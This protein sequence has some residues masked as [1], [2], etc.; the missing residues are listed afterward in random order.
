MQ[1]RDRTNRSD[2]ERE[3]KENKKSPFFT[4]KN[5]ELRFDWL[6]RFHYWWLGGRSITRSIF[7]ITAAWQGVMLIGGILIALF[8][9]AAFYTQSG[10]FVIRVDHPGEKLLV[11]SDTTDF[12]EELITLNGTAIN[13]A[14]NISI[15]DIDPEVAEIDGDHNGPDYVAYTFY[16]KNIGYD[17]ITYNYTLSIQRQTKGIDEA[18]WVLLYHN[19]EQQILAKQSKSGDAES[20]SSNFEFPFQEAARY[21]DQYT[22][23]EKTELYTLTTKPFASSKIIATDI[24]EDIQPE[25]YDKY[26]VVMWLEGEDPECINDILGGSIEVM[27]KFRY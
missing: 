6:R 25:E 5:G 16:I 8:I 14:D 15:F 9:M 18:V 20:Q 26:T 10:E 7:R 1:K 13:D 19:G 22:Y 12:S 23:S 2:D 17:P 3:V 4:K 27:M 11:L 21:E 24:R